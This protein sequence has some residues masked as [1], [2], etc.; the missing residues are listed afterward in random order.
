MEYRHAGNSGLVVSLVGLGC[1]N[2]GRV[3]ATHQHLE[4]RTSREV[5]EAALEAGITF[6]DTAIS[7]DHSEDLVGKYLEKYRDDLVIGTKFGQPADPAIVPVLAN[8]FG[9]RGAR[10]YVRLAVEESLR[11]L[12]T[13][14][15][16]LY[17]LHRPDPMT[18]IEET[19][20]VLTDLVHE[21][22]I[23]YFG[24]SNVKGWQLADAES[25]SR[26]H[27][28]ERFVT[29]QNR[30]NILDRSI[31]EEVLPACSH[32][33]IGIIPFSPLAQGLLTGKYRRG[34]PLPKG[35]RLAVVNRPPAER[36]F[37][38]LEAL[39]T[40]AAERGISLL[41]IAFGGLAAEKAVCSIIAGATSADQVRANV[42]AASW[43]PEPEEIAE[44]R[45]ITG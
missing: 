16:D 14:R 45:R 34:E 5:I 33:G 20:S 32:Y 23:R 37:D 7:Y 29:V 38:Q 10:R 26:S 28:F 11:R 12:R 44:L 24:I 1:I 31:E 13:D 22:K 42:A 36:H 21:G 8:D 2:F 3:D 25:L 4:E 35:S 9:A 19:L 15:I 17:Q 39:G 43:V 41:E 30:Y 40:F 27:G 6:F 18:P